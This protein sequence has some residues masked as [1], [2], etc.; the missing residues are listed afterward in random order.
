MRKPHPELVNTRR[1]QIVNAATAVIAEQG[2]QGLSLSAIEQKADMA[3]GQLTYYFR[4]KEEILLAVFDRALERIH[5]RVGRAAEGVCPGCPESGWEWVQ[6]LL[7]LILTRPPADPEF[8][9]LQHTFLAQVGHRE[10]FR[11]R[12]SSLYERW[13]SDMAAGLAADAAQGRCRRTVPPRALASVVQALL[14]GLS[15]QALA[16]P[17]AFDRQEVLNLCLDMLGTYLGV[18]GSPAPRNGRPA[19]ATR[20]LQR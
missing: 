9:C 11:Q 4:T 19:P 7:T 12:L 10:D 8:G 13:R 18:Q 16:D 3:R 20:R 6:L 17:A 15:V 1:E 5:E 14:H 2:I